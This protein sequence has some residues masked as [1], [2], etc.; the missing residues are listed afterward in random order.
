LV[1]PGFSLK[2]RSMPA[3]CRRCDA[4]FDSSR[5]D[6]TEQRSIVARTRRARG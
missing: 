6:P 5:G 4:G 3:R 2:K 1:N